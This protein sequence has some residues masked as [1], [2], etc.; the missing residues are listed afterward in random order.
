[1][2]R[3]LPRQRHRPKHHAALDYADLPEAIE[4]IRADCGGAA[5]KLAAEFIILTAG[6]SSEITGARWAEI[7]HE[8]ATWTVPANRMK[9]RVE[10][11]VPLSAGR[12]KCWQR[13]GRCPMAM[14]SYSRPLC[15]Q[16]IVPQSLRDL[17][18]RAGIMNVTIHG[19]RS[20]IQDWMAE[21]TSTPYAIAMSVIAHGNPNKAGPRLSP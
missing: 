15:R 8:A 5:V 12:W 1:M 21:Q 7:D 18:R 19:F 3:L 2:G 17:L 9:A 16:A 10:H 14:A 11:R 6:R 13:R 20:A 4:R